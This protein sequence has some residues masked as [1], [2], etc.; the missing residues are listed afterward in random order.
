M[1]FVDNTSLAGVQ[2]VQ[3][4]VRV[5][6]VSRTAIKALG[7]NAF[8]VGED[9]FGATTIGPSA[10]VPLAPINIGA[11]AGALAN[12]DIP[13]AFPS[14]VGPTSAI[15]L[16]GGL[17]G[18]NAMAFVQ[19]L[20]ENQYLRIL[21]E[22]TLV[23]LSGEEASFLAGGEF[24]IPVVQGGS[25][26]GST[27]ISI[28]YKKFGIRLNFR[29]LVLGE[30][31]IRLRVEPEV[32]EL[33]DTG[34]VVIEGFRIPGII[35]RRS[36]TTVELK[37]GQSFAMAG[38]ISSR[39]ESRNSKIPIL[40]DIPIL[41]ALF[42]SIRYSKGETELVVLVTASLIEPLSIT[43][44]PLPGSLPEE[45]TDWEIFVEGELK[46]SVTAAPSES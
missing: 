42:R 40:G 9:A 22:P 33:T 24:P 30:G 4:Q 3:I 18:H 26:S 12:P 19:A 31:R 14:D 46:G 32:S 25:A 39:Q 36:K 38:L 20:A 2:Q 35:T 10:G 21:A 43:S 28:I 34:A 17:T 8:Q 44:A 41:G 7:V 23:A 5:A 13:F 29:P 1:K 11:P 15:T 37:S 16:F 27:S 45:E 6:E